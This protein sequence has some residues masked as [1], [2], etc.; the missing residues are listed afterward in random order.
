[1]RAH[2]AWTSGSTR[3]DR[4]LVQ[5]VPGLLLKSGA[6][7]VQGLALADGRAIALKIDDGDGTRRVR[8]AV[9]VA[10]LRAIGADDRP[11]T[12]RAVLD[13]LARPAVYGGGRVVGEVRVK[14]PF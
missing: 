12:D 5:A 2:P 8:I 10:L 9:A 14:L 1:M 13:E 3:P 4:R 7:G 11:G 6:E